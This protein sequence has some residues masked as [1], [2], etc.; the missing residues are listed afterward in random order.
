MKDLISKLKEIEHK[1]ADEK[2]GYQLFAIF[3]REDSIDKWDLLVASNWINTDKEASLKYLAKTIQDILTEKELLLF[4]R[5]VII[6]DTNPILTALPQFVQVVH[7]DVEIKDTNLFGLQIK[8][9]I[10]ITCIGMNTA[11]EKI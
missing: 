6:E 1:T 2:G 5:I 3:L 10:L 4:S 9:A 11:T 7:S 8:H